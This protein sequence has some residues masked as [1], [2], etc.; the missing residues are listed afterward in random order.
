MN[1][2]KEYEAE[3]GDKIIKG[4]INDK[5]LIEA[6]NMRYL[7]WLEKELKNRDKQIDD[8]KKVIVD[9]RDKVHTI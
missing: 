3:T 7:N 5:I 1:Y 2:K 9:F 8:M 6:H 4:Q